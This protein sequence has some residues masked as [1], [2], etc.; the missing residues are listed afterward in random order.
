MWQRMRSLWLGISE[1]SWAG[2]WLLDILHKQSIGGRAE[3]WARRQAGPRPMS[4]ATRS[5]S[6]TDPIADPISG[7]GHTGGLQ[8]LKNTRRARRA[9]GAWVQASS[10]TIVRN[11]PELQRRRTVGDTLETSMYVC[12]P[13]NCSRMQ[14]RR[15]TILYVNFYIMKGYICSFR[16]VESL[17]CVVHV[18]MGFLAWMCRCH[19]RSEENE[20]LWLL[21]V[22]FEHPHNMW[23]RKKELLANSFFCSCFKK[24]WV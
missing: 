13:E 2:A 16:C 23:I 6:A 19:K 5:R 11:V 22:R 18:H 7:S 14:S 24:G 3:G 21:L 17:R 8:H 15:R 1:G 20:A 10:R 9:G 12:N 4:E